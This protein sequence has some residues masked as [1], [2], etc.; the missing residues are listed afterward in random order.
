MGPGSPYLARGRR[1]TVGGW[2]PS[3][4]GRPVLPTPTRSRTTTTAASSPLVVAVDDGTPIGHVTVSGHRLVHLFV[5]PGHQGRGLGRLLLARG[6]AMLRAGGHADLEQH[7]RVENVAAIAFYVSQG[8]TVTDRLI[9]TVE[10][11]IS[12]DEWVLVTRIS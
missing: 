6:E 7:A 9:R 3:S 12:Y 10:H 1:A 5:E 8:W 4:S 11:G 2:P